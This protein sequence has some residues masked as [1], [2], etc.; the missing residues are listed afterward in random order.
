MTGEC[1]KCLQRVGYHDITVVLS[2]FGLVDDGIGTAF[3][4]GHFGKTVAVERCAF[5]S[6][7]YCTLRTVAT[8]GSD[9]RML[10]KCLI[11]PFCVHNP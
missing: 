7:E 5:E 11:K 2:I 6:E 1:L 9:E 3:L 8:V 10:A 4:Q